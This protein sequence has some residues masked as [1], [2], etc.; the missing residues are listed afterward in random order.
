MELEQK[1]GIQIASDLHL[2]M[3]ENSTYLKNNP[4]IPKGKVLI[5]GGDIAPIHLC[6]QGKYSDFFSYC[7]DHFEKTYW[8]AGNHEF[9]NGD[10][11]N[12]TGHFEERIRSNVYLVNN[13]IANFKTVEIVLST[14]WTKISDRKSDHIRWSMNDYRAIRLA[15]K[16][17]TIEDTNR[18]F[19]ENIAF[20]NGALANNIAGKRLVVTHHVPT[21]NNYPAVYAGSLLNEAF[22]VDLNTIIENAKIDY[23]VFGHHHANVEA[24]CVGNTNLMTNQLGYTWLKEHVGFDPGLVIGV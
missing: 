18:L 23:W 2:E 13:Y 20:I 6:N 9:Y 11:A 19:D 21:F 24:F 1:D 8:I 15:G 10:M 17:L 14:L 16:K 4:L 7:G 12:Y 22:A 3:L 5:L